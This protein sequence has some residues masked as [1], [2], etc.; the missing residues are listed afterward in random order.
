MG[1]W[2]EKRTRGGEIQRL[3]GNGLLLVEALARVDERKKTEEN[4]GG[5]PSRLRV[6]N[7]YLRT[8]DLSEETTQEL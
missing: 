8:V 1:R 5:S 4:R 2:E 3:T 7:R 6:R